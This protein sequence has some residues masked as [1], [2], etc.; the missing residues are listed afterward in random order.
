MQ[1][2][3]TRGSRERVFDAKSRKA[4]EVAVRRTQGEA[5]LDRKRGQVRIGHELRARDDAAQEAVH[6]LAVALGR[7]G[8]P[9]RRAVEPFC[10][11]LPGLSNAGRS[12]ENP[13]V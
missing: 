1:S 8:D 12:I 13:R 2:P 11:A 4:S 3:E 9:G 5:V 6:E 10:C 7:L